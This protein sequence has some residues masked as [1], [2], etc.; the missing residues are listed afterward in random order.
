VD[1]R[2]LN[3]QDDALLLS[4]KS[5]FPSE[6]LFSSFTTQPLHHHTTQAEHTLAVMSL[7]Y[8]P[9]R[10]HRHWEHRNTLLI[11][12][13]VGLRTSR[14]RDAPVLLPDC[15]HALQGEAWTLRV[16]LQQPSGCQATIW[17]EGM[18]GSSGI[19]HSGADMS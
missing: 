17:N 1:R 19:W 16:H 13:C 3:S 7:I 5:P 14:F 9:V 6:L 12:C 8:A 4:R 15:A 18:S 2:Q 11:I 10:R